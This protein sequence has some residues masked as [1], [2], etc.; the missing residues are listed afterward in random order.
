[1]LSVRPFIYFYYCVVCPSFCLFLLLCCLSVLLSIFTIVLSV[2]PFV[3]FY[4]CVV[5]SSFCL[6]LLLCCLSVL[7]SIFII[8]LSVRPFVYFYYLTDNTTVKI[9]KRT[10]RQHNSKNRQKDGQTTQ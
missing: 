9:D 3:Y 8:V 1:V 2:L 4:Y 10:D 7:L 5:C 6:F